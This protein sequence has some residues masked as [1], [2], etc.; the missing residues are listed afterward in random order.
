L[1]I[2]YIHPFIV[3][4]VLL[5]SCAQK[6]EKIKA[7][8]APKAPPPQQVEVFIIEANTIQENIELPGTIL[9]GDETTLQPEIS[10]RLTYLNIPEGKTVAKGTLIATIY[11]GDLRA[12]LQKLKTQLDVQQEKV[13]RYEALLKI[14]GVSKQEF[15]LIKLE[16]ANIQADIAIVETNLKRTQ[17]RAPF[18]GQL[19]LKQ[20]SSGAYVS[21]QTIL[22]TIRNMSDLVID[23]SIP[24]KYTAR[25][26]IG[27]TV[28][29]NIEG[30]NNKYE[31]KVFA[32][33]SGITEND[34]NLKLRARI[35]NRDASLL[36]GNFV[37]VK[38]QFEPRNNAI[39]IP[40]NA[41]IPQARTKQVAV[42]KNGIVHLTSVETGFRD[43]ARVEI[44]NGL[45]IGD[46]IV[47]TG[48][49]RIKDQDKVQVAKGESP[50]KP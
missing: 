20:V 14:D 21:P 30:S 26:G 16:T 24:E 22:T 40:S 31:A 25:I 11:D 1:K 19:G 37:K 46:T 49:M 28:Q 2:K 33:E 42:V 17:I 29:F 45:E 39:M 12:Q 5:F 7:T 43:S 13:K 15:D 34:R 18:T 6:N 10:G 23:F 9:S 41:V 48:L 50:N 47:T 32:S 4:S 44:I 8:D 27:T 3:L 36:P 35:I 38:V